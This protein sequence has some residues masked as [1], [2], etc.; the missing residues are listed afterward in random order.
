MMK[1]L[2]QSPGGGH[3]HSHGGGHGHSHGGG[4]HGHGGE[5]NINVRAA[6]IHV[7]GDLLQSIGVMVAAGIIWAKPD[8]HIA[9]PV[10]TFNFAILVLFTTVGV[11]KQ[12]LATLLNSVP[13]HIDLPSF[14]AELGGIKGVANVHDLHG[15]YLL[16]FDV[17]MMMRARPVRWEEGQAWGAANDTIGR[18]ETQFETRRRM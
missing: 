17:R 12:G 1:I 3:G 15:A 10:C 16:S 4:G 14:A 8:A 18:V 2:H 7:L 13:S 9:D 11:M 6:F 5:E